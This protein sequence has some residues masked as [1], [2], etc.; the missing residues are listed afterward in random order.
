M[1]LFH[2]NLLVPWVRVTKVLP[3]L[4]MLNIAGALTS[5]QSFLEKGSTLEK[6]NQVIYPHN[7]IHQP[8]LAARLLPSMQVI[9]TLLQVTNTS[10]RPVSVYC[11]RFNKFIHKLVRE[12]NFAALMTADRVRFSSTYASLY[13]TPN[14]GDR[15]YMSFVALK[16]GKIRATSSRYSCEFME[17]Y[18]RNEVL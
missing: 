2:V 7:L 8:G 16:Q 14:S 6:E 15:K 12:T 1:N 10:W 17:N 5:Y 4:R 18:L 13:Q 3:R 9:S 11:A